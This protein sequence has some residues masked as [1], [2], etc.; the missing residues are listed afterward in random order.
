MP[1]TYS[2]NGHAFGSMWTFESN[3]PSKKSHFF[4]VHILTLA[5]DKKL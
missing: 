4:V 3:W 1:Q 5:W 2:Q